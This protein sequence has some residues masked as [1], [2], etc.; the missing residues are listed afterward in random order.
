MGP[1]AQPQWVPWGGFTHPGVPWGFQPLG[2]LKCSLKHHYIFSRAGAV[3]LGGDRA[4]PWQHPCS[5][6]WG[7]P[8][9]RAGVW[10]HP[11]FPCQP[12]EGTCTPVLVWPPRAPSPLPAT[13]GP[14]W[15]PPGPP[16][17]WGGPRRLGGDA[18]I[19]NKGF[20]LKIPLPP[21]S[22]VAKYSPGSSAISSASRVGSRHLPACAAT[23]GCGARDGVGSTMLLAGGD[24]APGIPLPGTWVTVPLRSPCSCWDDG[25]PAT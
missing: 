3:S 20:F 11:P 21:S 2:C 14:P 6:P 4:P 18:G 13:P 25:C 10:V 8:P 23:V 15:P 9:R 16:A 17:L 1:R 5:P 22:A 24:G 7:H 19:K 12:R